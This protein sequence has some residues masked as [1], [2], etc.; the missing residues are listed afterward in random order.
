MY[1]HVFILLNLRTYRGRFT[2]PIYFP[3]I[4]FSTI[5]SSMI[6]YTYAYRFIHLLSYFHIQSHTYI[7]THTFSY[8]VLYFRT[9]INKYIHVYIY[10]LYPNITCFLVY[11]SFLSYKYIYILIH[12]ISYIQVHL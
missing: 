7:Y 10:S 8:I 6:S 12:I 5:F 1:I 3:L 4:T 9:N 2:F 11:L